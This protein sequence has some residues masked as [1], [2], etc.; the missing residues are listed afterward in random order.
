MP[1]VLNL[2]KQGDVQP[3]RF[4]LGFLALEEVGNREK[5]DLVSPICSDFRS[6]FEALKITQ[7]VVANPELQPLLTPVGQA[8]DLEA[9]KVPVPPDGFLAN[10]AIDSIL[11]SRNRNS[12]G[13]A[14][15]VTR[16]KSTVLRSMP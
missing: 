1:G 4:T 11:G 14:S 7:Q 12:S 5:G 2:F 10:S 16:S 9:R 13:V 3:I 6:G 15:A 8:T